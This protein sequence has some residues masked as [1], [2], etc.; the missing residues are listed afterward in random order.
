MFSLL[1]YVLIGLFLFMGFTIL[2][3]KPE[4]F[5]KKVLTKGIG[6]M[7]GVA[8]ALMALMTVGVIV[9]RGL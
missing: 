2:Q 3:R 5:E 6:T 1:I 7:G 4:L 9:L 8:L